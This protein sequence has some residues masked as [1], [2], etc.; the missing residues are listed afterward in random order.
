M[1]IALPRLNGLEATRQ[2]LK[3]RPA[4][5][6]LVLS[7]HGDD[8]YIEQARILG[9]AGYLV[10]QTS[11][12]ILARAIRTVNNGAV[13][14]SSATPGCLHKQYDSAASRCLSCMSGNTCMTSREVE[15]LQLVAEGLANKQIAAE[16]GISIKTVEKHR[17]KLTRKL[18]IHDTAS[19]T[20]YAISIGI[21]ENNLRLTTA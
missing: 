5:K 10:K 3:T 12:Q 19:L 9:A 18:N 20:R 21:I 16:L 17:D 13:F 14:F 4:T 7:A 1:D 15:V 8:K 11:A 6:V 2:M